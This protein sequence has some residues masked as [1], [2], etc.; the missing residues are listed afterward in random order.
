MAVFTPKPIVLSSINNGNKYN[1]GDSI[2]ANAINS[3]IEAA[4]YAQDLSERAFKFA[5]NVRGDI[6]Y[7]S[8]RLDNLEARLS[9]DVFITDSEVTA[10]KIVPENV[11]PYAKIVA[12]GGMTYRDEATNTLKN[13]KVTALKSKGANLFD[14]DKFLSLSGNSEFYS[15]NDSGELLVI[16]YDTRANTVIEPIMT[17]PAGTYY[18]QF[19]SATVGRAAYE[20][21]ITGTNTSLI[22]YSNPEIITL[23]EE[24]QIS[25][26]FVKSTFANYGN[27]QVHRGTERQEFYPYSAEPID[28]LTLP[29]AVQNREGYGLG[30]PEISNYFR[31]NDGK[32]EEL[33]YCKELILDGENVYATGTSVANGYNYFIIHLSYFGI[34]GAYNNY[35]F[36]S[37]D[38]TIDMVAEPGYAYIAGEGFTTILC[39]PVDQTLD[40][41]DKVN[42]WAKERY[43]SGNPIKF[44]VGAKTPTI[45]DIT[46]LMPADNLLKVQQGGAIV[47]VN[48]YG[49]AAPTTIKYQ[50]RS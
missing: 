31:Y 39:Y 49:L 9:D 13:A 37:T 34:E 3:P 46:H 24:T 45:T 38:Y 30:T 7:N 20:A 47:P 42:T 28:T 2:Q 11:A 48:E 50:K 8:K 43:A 6:D 12:V 18:V 44:V 10:E 5:E 40:T 14:I 33:N 22:S 19:D 41:V 15:K 25:M 21:F 23:T 35:S 16:G 1:N 4:A 32:V 26:K 17:L 29:E 36:V 27:V